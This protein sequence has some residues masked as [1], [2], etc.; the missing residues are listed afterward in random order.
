VLGHRRLREVRAYDRAEFLEFRRLAEVHHMRV[1][2]FPADQ[3]VIA[4]PGFDATL[5]FV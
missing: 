1:D 2:R 5:Q 4:A 3:E